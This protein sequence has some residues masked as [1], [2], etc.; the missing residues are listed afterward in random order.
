MNEERNLI[1]DSDP[2]YPEIAVT[3]TH[4]PKTKFLDL[5]TIS[6]TN[7]VLFCMSKNGAAIFPPWNCHRASSLNSYSFYQNIRTESVVE[8]EVNWISGEK[9]EAIM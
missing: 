6:A 3:Q 7:E 1:E 5:Q 9:I 8:N 2:L 4:A